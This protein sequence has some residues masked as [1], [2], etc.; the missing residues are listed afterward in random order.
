MTS[1]QNSWFDLHLWY[2]SGLLYNL[3]L[4]RIDNQTFEELWNCA[5]QHDHVSVMFLLMQWDDM[6]LGHWPDSVHI[7]NSGGSCDVGGNF[8]H[9]CALLQQILRDHNLWLIT[10]YNLTDTLMWQVHPPLVQPSS[11]QVWDIGIFCGKPCPM[12]R[13]RD[14]TQ[15][16]P[17]VVHNL[18]TWVHLRNRG[19]RQGRDE[20]TKRC[21]FND[22]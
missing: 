14:W 17:G 18:C 21:R 15:L 3:C 4:N 2:S 5:C 9:L 6:F 7:S 22:V 16:W 12:Q 20:T 1:E 13:G 11:S 19:S 8:Q 10:Y